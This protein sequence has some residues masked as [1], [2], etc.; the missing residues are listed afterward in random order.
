MYVC[1]S[2]VNH[3]QRGWS[4]EGIKQYNVLFELVNT[5]RKDHLEVDKH[6]LDEIKQTVGTRKQKAAEPIPKA[7]SL[8]DIDNTDDEAVSD[9]SS[10][11]ED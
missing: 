1:K 10:N 7:M 9:S 2:R 3:N 4:G 11:E 6:W 8:W 5:A